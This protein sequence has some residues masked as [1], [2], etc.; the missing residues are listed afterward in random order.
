MKVDLAV[1]GGGSGGYIAARRAA[2]LG[3]RVAVVECRH[4][5]GVCLNRGCVPT[6]TMV[7]AVRIANQIR[8]AAAYGVVV[9][10]EPAIDYAALLAKRDEVVE[11][12]RTGLGDLLQL[13]GIP[14]I[15]GRAS[16]AGPNTLAITPV[17]A[18]VAAGLGSMGSTVDTL[19]AGHI[20]IATGSRPAGL[21]PDCVAHPRV[22]DS[23]GALA[24][25]ALPSSLLVVGAGP[26]GCE[27]SFI[28]AGLG[29]KV[30]LVTRRPHVLP[31]EDPD[32]GAVLAETLRAMD[33]TIHTGTRVASIVGA[34]DDVEVE[35]DGE[36]QRTVTAEYVLVAAGRLPLTEGLE[37]ESIGIET[38]GAGW[39]KVD[40]YLRTNVPS[41]LAI[42]D[43][44]GRCLLAHVAFSHAVIAVEKLAGLSPKPARADRIPN[45]VY[46]E[47]EVASVGL[48]EAQAREGGLGISI[49]E[50]PNFAN[51]RAVTRGQ[52]EGFVKVVADSGS[53]RVLGVHMIGPD[54]GELIADAVSALEKEWTLDE[55]AEVMRPHPT[56]CESLGEACLT[57]A[58]R[59]LFSV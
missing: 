2:Q 6:K 40:D 57:A 35:L 19:D 43:V 8:R 54:A 59:P 3:M 34:E 45:V 39:V 50:F 27:W 18:E 32:L 33:V 31:Q 1:L 55:V 20:V 30:T 14:V 17:S 4:L 48:T 52:E 29:C 28:F 37:L 47:P 7:Q 15:P 12:L 25:K 56:L 9:A 23:D 22:I 24:L 10:G 42:G 11:R 13:A 36:C 51:A 38:E 58:G 26:I 44:T 21:P 16:F 41:V 5:G 53:G 49:G 46:T